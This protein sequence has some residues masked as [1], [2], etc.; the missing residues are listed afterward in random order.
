MSLA[1]WSGNS[2]RKIVERIVIEGELILETP[3]HFGN[4]D[5]DDITDMPLLVDAFDGKSPLLTGASITGALRSYLR[6]RQYGYRHPKPQN[7][8]DARKEN[9]ESNASLLFGGLNGYDEGEQSP[10]IVDDAR[11]INPGIEMRN[12]VKLN[13]SS[14][15]AEND[16]LFDMQLWQAGTKFPLRFELAIR[17]TDNAAQIKTSLASALKGF[18]DGGITLGARKRRG[19]GRVRVDAWRVKIYNVKTPIGL[20]D[21]VENGGKSPS[22]APTNDINTVLGTGVLIDDARRVFQMKATFAL[23][24]SLLIRSGGGR[25][26]KGPDMVYLSAHQADGSTQ[27]VL[28]G[29]SMAGALRARATKIAKSLDRLGNM[30]ILIDGMFGAEMNNQRGNRASASPISPTASRVA[31]REEIVKETV[32][33]LVQNRVSIDRFTAGARDTALFNEQPVFGGEVIVDVQLANPKKEEIGLLL[34]LLKDLW[35]GDL[36]LGGESSVGRG[37]LK[38]KKAELIYKTPETQDGSFLWSLEAGANALS[39][40]E[41][42]RERLEDFVTAFKT[43]LRG[44]TYDT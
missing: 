23:D 25:E 11:G 35:T 33:N 3:A 36:A 8:A 32:T 9:E 12:G 28:S 2:S 24:G 20:I 4:G 15:T 22:V 5:G 10:L 14:R 37:R 38:G 30:R 18:K 34:L 29:T 16:A 27:P 17:A 31:V 39:I 40:P 44:V 6:S 1:M 41:E 26:D 21:W 43:Y 19:Y 7:K 13:S 42:A